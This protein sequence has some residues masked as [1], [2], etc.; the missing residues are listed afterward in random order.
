[1]NQVEMSEWKNIKIDLR[2]SMED[3]NIRLSEMDR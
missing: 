3:F 2:N 1:M